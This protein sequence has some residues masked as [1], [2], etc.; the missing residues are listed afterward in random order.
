MKLIRKRKKAHELAG[1]LNPGDCFELSDGSVRMVVRT[2]KGFDLN[3]VSTVDL[4]TGDFDCYD[5]GDQLR[6]I[7][8]EAVVY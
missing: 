1:D 6:P 4:Q 7:T 8:V 5:K 3:R 2:P